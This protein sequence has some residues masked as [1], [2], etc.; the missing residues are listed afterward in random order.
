MKTEKKVW[1]IASVYAISIIT[2]AIMLTSC[3]ASKGCHNKGYYVSKDIK[4]AQGK[5]RF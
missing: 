4:K 5:S 2:I 1:T 3:G